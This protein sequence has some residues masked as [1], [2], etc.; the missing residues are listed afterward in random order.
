MPLVYAL[1]LFLLGVVYN[2]EFEIAIFL[3]VCYFAVLRKELASWPGAY[4]ID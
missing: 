2:Q 4:Y 1:I 3:F